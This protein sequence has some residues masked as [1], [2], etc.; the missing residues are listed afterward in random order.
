MSCNVGSQA[1]NFAIQIF[2]QSFVLISIKIKK[3]EMFSS[4]IMFLLQSKKNIIKFCTS[5]QHPSQK[6]TKTYRISS[7]TFTQEPQTLL[8]MSGK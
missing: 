1:G 4:R 6:Q 5:P 8:K 7:G 3:A 2:F